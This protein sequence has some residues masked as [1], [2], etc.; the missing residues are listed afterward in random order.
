LKEKA[1]KLVE[2]H[3]ANHPKEKAKAEKILYPYLAASALYA[4]RWKWD[5]AIGLRKTKTK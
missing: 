1:I 4:C 3:F 5:P 2:D